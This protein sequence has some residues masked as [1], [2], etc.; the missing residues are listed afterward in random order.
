MHNK[1]KNI[2]LVYGM[3]NAVQP[4]LPI[5]NIKMFHYYIT[6]NI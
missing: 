5:K 3:K 2:E 1:P 4:I 6:Y